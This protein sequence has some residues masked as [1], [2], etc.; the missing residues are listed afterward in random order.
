MRSHKFGNQVYIV[1][2]SDGWIKVGRGISAIK[3]IKTHEGTSRIRGAE[4]V[5]KYS[6]ITIYNAHAVEKAMINYCMSASES[7]SGREWHKG[8]SFDRLVEIANEKG[9]ASP[10][11]LTAAQAE[12]DECL[13]R[14]GEFFV[15]KK[16]ESEANQIEDFKASIAHA[17]TIQRVMAEDLFWCA[18]FVDCNEGVSKFVARCALIVGFMSSGEIAELYNLALTDPLAC[19]NFVSSQW[20]LILADYTASGIAEEEYW[21]SWPMACVQ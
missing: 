4:V 2:F 21:P 12:L 3:R 10:E 13:R 20:L 14:V 7:S 6:S 15:N 5:K 16:S 1:K 17:E 8:V 11:N 9:D 19:F 18:D